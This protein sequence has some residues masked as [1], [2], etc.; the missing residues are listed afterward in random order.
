MTFDSDLFCINCMWQKETAGVCMRCGFDERSYH[1]SPHHLKPRSILN[2]K[3]IVGKSLGEGG[4]G[5]TYL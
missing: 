1:V 4:F 5:I 3:Y 2:G